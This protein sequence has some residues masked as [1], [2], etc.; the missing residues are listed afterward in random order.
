MWEVNIRKEREIHPGMWRTQQKA[1]H[2]GY[3]HA[4]AM[5]REVVEKIRER[6]T[7]L[8]QASQQT[9]STITQ[10]FIQPPKLLLNFVQIP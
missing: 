8:A 5:E 1:R 4:K 7:N 6:E 2:V 10:A 3:K 9:E